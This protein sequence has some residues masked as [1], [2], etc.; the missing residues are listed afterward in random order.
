MKIDVLEITEELIKL[1]TWLGEHKVKVTTMNQGVETFISE[2]NATFVGQAG[3][4]MR[5]CMKDIFTPL[6]QQFEVAEQ[7]VTQSIDKIKQHAQSEFGESGIV[8]ETYLDEWSSEMRRIVQQ[9]DDV[10]GNI[11]SEFRKVSDLISVSPIN[12]DGFLET[13]HNTMRYITQLKDKMHEFEAMANAEVA[14]AN[15]EVNKLILMT[16][17]VNTFKGD[18]ATYK[19]GSFTFKTLNKMTSEQQAKYDKLPQEFKESIDKGYTKVDDYELTNDGMILCKKTFWEIDPEKFK[20]S[21]IKDWCPYCVKVDGEAEYGVCKFGTSIDDNGQPYTSTSFRLSFANINPKDIENIMTGKA[22]SE[23]ML[24]I[25]ESTIG[26]KN[27]T[28]DR[29][30]KYFSNTKNEGAY[31]LSDVY[32]KK[33][34][35]KMKANGQLEIDLGANYGKLMGNEKQ[36]KRLEELGCVENGKLKIKDPNKLSREEYES[37]LTAYCG[38]TSAHNFAAEIYLHAVNVHTWGAEKNAQIADH[39]AGTVERSYIKEVLEYMVFDSQI[40]GVTKSFKQDHED[41]FAEIHGWS[42]QSEPP[43]EPPWGDQPEPK[44]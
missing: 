20:D 25:E 21:K 13:E 43:S 7:T 37:I 18:M 23:G 2:S 15:D 35:D 42:S 33:V 34:I 32:V 8:S 11:D 16:N 1:K 17:D 29:L 10:C 24:E 40:D 31:L 44:V 6:N 41:K 5:A 39:S 3:D 26:G 38:N 30:A 28:N 4:G 14:R 19:A 22:T 9:Y 12:R 36:R 27:P